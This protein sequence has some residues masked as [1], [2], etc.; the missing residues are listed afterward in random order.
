MTS[1]VSNG[2]RIASVHQ[3]T[4]G[5]QSWVKPDTARGQTHARF[6]QPQ[7]MRWVTRAAAGGQP[8][9]RQ[10]TSGDRLP[11]C[12]V[13]PGRFGVGLSRRGR[14]HPPLSARRGARAARSG[15]RPP[16]RAARP[17]A[18]PTMTDGRTRDVSSA[19]DGSLT[20]GYCRCLISADHPRQ[21][22]DRPRIVDV[23]PRAQVRMVSSG[24]RSPTL[25]QCVMRTAPRS[26]VYLDTSTSTD[27]QPQPPGSQVSYQGGSD[28]SRACRCSS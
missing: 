13:R 27:R 26:R 7:R 19:G 20:R 3:L 6:G 22:T 5:R 10:P 25:D 14:I 21:N 9:L 1:E 16:D 17:P 23:V 2:Q 18:R 4:I 24:G 12:V 15:L 8:R 11:R 28:E